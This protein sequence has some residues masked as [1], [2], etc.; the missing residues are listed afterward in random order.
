MRS[1]CGRS[2][3][4]IQSLCLNRIL[5]GLHLLPVGLFRSSL[6]GFRSGLS[7]AYVLLFAVYVVQKPILGS[8]LSQLC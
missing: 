3:S 1:L 2:L 8:I 6:V 4:L 5:S 7:W